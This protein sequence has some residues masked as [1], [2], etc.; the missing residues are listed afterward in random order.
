M[1]LIFTTALYHRYLFFDNVINANI[2]VILNSVNILFD[3]LFQP[4]KLRG[5]KKLS[6]SYAQAITDHLYGKQFRI[7]TLSI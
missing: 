7:L 2:K 5:C 3:F 6:K 4:V 1:S